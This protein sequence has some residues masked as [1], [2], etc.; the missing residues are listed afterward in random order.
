MFDLAV[1]DVTVCHLCLGSLGVWLQQQGSWCPNV[2]RS[3]PWKPGGLHQQLL[4][5]HAAKALVPVGRK[6]AGGGTATCAQL[7]AH[8]SCILLLIVHRHVGCTAWS[9]QAGP[10]AWG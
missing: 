1:S 3:R 9:R 6:A 2:V 7:R 5:G 10:F 8:M 4:V